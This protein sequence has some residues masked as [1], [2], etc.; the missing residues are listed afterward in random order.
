M[1]KI[2]VDNG[3][4]VILD[5]E[6]EQYKLNLACDHP[7]FGKIYYFSNIVNMPY[8]RLAG[9]QTIVEFT[10]IGISQDEAKKELENVLEL[11]KAGDYMNAYAKGDQLKNKISDFWNHYKT[12]LFLIGLIFVHESQLGSIGVYEQEISE[13]NINDWT[14]DKDLIGFFLQRLQILSN[15]SKNTLDLDMANYL[16]NQTKTILEQSKIESKVSA[17]ESTIS[18]KSFFKWLRNRIKSVIH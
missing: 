5:N 15:N 16:Q 10:K 9:Y 6:K 13:K 11:M 12:N 4:Y 14:K 8:L 17:N 1:Y 18:T 7:S 2:A 3:D